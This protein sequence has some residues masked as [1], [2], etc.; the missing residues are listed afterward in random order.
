MKGLV[1]LTAF[2]SKM[3]YPFSVRFV[4][5]YCKL[6]GYLN[7]H[8]GILPFIFMANGIVLGVY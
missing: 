1:F 8:M 7:V 3:I 2:T 5:K 6:E 4:K